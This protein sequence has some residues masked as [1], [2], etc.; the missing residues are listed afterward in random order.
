[1]IHNALVCFLFGVGAGI[2]L[3]IFI[4]SLATASKLG[5][6][7]TRNLE[8]EFRLEGLKRTLAEQRKIALKNGEFWIIG[9]RLSR[10][11]NKWKFLGV[12][13]SFATARELAFEYSEIMRAWKKRFSGVFVA[14]VRV[15][16]A[17][18]AVSSQLSRWKGLSFIT[19]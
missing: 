17:L 12:C 19:E 14:P 5:D 7:H 18:P 15:N 1:V 2:V 6:L 4:V 9:Q 11:G 16:L 13:A 3:G 10:T 8:L